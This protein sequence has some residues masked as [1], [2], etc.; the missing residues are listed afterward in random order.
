MLQ[1]RYAVSSR[2]RIS[3]QEQRQRA[4][5]KFLTVRPVI[6]KYQDLHECKLIPMAISQRERALY[7]DAWRPAAE[8]DGIQ[9]KTNPTKGNSPS[10]GTIRMAL[11]PA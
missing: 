5:A 3:E 11:K 6:R 9:I 8:I 10:D 1:R 2:R 4:M 7:A